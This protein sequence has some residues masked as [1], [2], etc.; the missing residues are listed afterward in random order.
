MDFKNRI[1]HAWNAFMGRDPTP[2]QYQD[3]GPAYSSPPITQSQRSYTD[4]SIINSIYNKIARDVAVISFVHCKTDKNGN[5]ME[6]IQ[7][8]LQE[9]LKVEANLDQ[10]GPALIQDAVTRM[11]KQGVVA[12]IP[13]DCDHNPDE[14]GTFDIYQIQCADILEWYPRKIKVRIWNPIKGQHEERF[15][16]K[17]TAAIVTNPMYDIMN[18]PNSI[19]QRINKK[20]ALLDVIDNESASTK[21]NMIVQVPYN[22]RSTM[23]QD[24]ANRRINEIE[25]QLADSPRGIAYMDINEKLIQL[26]RPLENNLLEHIKYLMDTYKQQLGISDELLNG[27]ANEVIWNNYVT[28]IIEPICVALTLEMKRKWL[29]KT[30]RT[31][32]QSIVFFKDPFRYVPTTEIAKIADVFSR[33]QIMTPNELRQKVG[34]PPADDPKADEL[35]NANMPDYPEAEPMMAPEQGMYPEEEQYM[36][37]QNEV[38]EEEPMAEEADYEPQEMTPEEFIERYGAPKK[39]SKS[40]TKTKEKSKESE[41]SEDSGGLFSVFSNEESSDNNKNGVFSLFK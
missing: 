2:E 21:L 12:I 36:E 34:M 38:P 18:E 15:F 41:E 22:T 8:P 3:L 10:T 14:T 19:L 1:K 32:G 5:Y 27:Q 17:E 35:N 13:T 24:Y 31:K 28:S 23:K 30:A 16:E 11:L 6:A 4:R 9:C 29:T 26:S 37:D 39:R 7:S 20:L 25:E 40:K 33:N